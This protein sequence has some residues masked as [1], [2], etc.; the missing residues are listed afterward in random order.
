MT[1][2]IQQWK[3][4]KKKNGRRKLTSM[5]NGRMELAEEEEAL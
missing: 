1:L 5:K 2:S 3:Q 4:W